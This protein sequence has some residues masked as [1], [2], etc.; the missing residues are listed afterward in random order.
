[1]LNELSIVHLCVTD[2]GG[3]G[4]CCRR[5]HQTMKD[6]GMNSHVLTMLKFSDDPDVERIHWGVK[7]FLY[8]ALNK[9]LLYLR[10]P[11]TDR[12]KIRMMEK[13]VGEPISMPTSVFKDLHKHP[14]IQQAD[15][16]H[17]HSVTG[18]ID[19]PSFFQKVNKPIVWTLHDENLFNGLAHFSRTAVPNKKIDK[20]YYNLKLSAL[21]T[22]KNLGIVFL[23]EMMYEK[24]HNH[25]MI[26]NNL[27]TIINNPINTN[28]FK[29]KDKSIARKAFNIA[30]DSLVFIF[31]AASISDPWK[32]L[33]TLSK[34]FETMDIHNAMILAVGKKNDKYK[35]PPYI[36]AIGPIYDTEKLSMAYSAADFFISSS[37]QEAFAQTPIEAMACG[38]PAIL[39]PV[40]GTSE[41][42]NE[43]NGVKCEG[44][45][46]EKIKKGI[47]KALSHKYD[48]D[49][50]RK[51]I[52]DRF[53][54]LRIAEKYLTFYK[55]M[56]NSK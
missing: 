36:K 41:L 38:T 54:T 4:L 28:I 25:D 49:I 14:L 50:I 52:I 56:I 35:Y 33:T 43:Q 44:F 29:P 2:E 12:V 51:D 24:Y 13:K 26:K 3:A 27:S 34:V 20:K 42:I 40:S 15:I 45:S 46:P 7:W 8:R 11:I 19:Y 55:A 17:L 32:G 39:T 47:I 21:R 30:D 6:M 22:A 5:I 23:S 9:V 48:S 31:V 16:I 53:S 1:M 10:L 37:T 18:F